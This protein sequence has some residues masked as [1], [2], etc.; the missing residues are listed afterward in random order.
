MTPLEVMAHHDLDEDTDR[1]RTCAGWWPC[2][3]WL[4]AHDRPGPQRPTRTTPC[5]R[6]T[7]GM[8]PVAVLLLVA[9]ALHRAGASDRRTGLL[10][11]DAWHTRTVPILGRTRRP[12]EHC[13]LLMIDVDRFKRVNDTHG[14]LVGDRVLEAISRIVRGA[15][16]DGDV[17]GRFG[18]DEF[19][20][21]LD[22]LD[23]PTAV[24]S[25]AERIRQDVAALHLPV[26]A[27][28]GAIEV[29]DLSVSIGGVIAR[30]TQH[31][32]GLAALLWAA[33]RALYAAKHGGRN[34]VRL[35]SVGPVGC[36]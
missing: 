4:H 27:R 17:V 13:G 1:C 18:G 36:V 22:H 16:R 10:T 25:I 5:C 31:S 15:V 12:D 3:T 7:S 6:A 33:D 21:F 29:T 19:V 28:D 8:F 30:G 20:V 26:E 14:H 24:G 32:D 35:R 9:A 34:A 2:S 11:H 23:S